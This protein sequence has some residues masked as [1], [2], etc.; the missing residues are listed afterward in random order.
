MRILPAVFCIVLGVALSACGGGGSANVTPAGSGNPN[1]APALTQ[2]TTLQRN[3]AQQGLSTTYTARNMV[4]DT[5]GS[6]STLA[7]VRRAVEARRFSAATTGCVDSEIETT[8]VISSTVENL[9]I[10][11]Y[12]D[13]ACTQLAVLGQFVLTVTSST[14]ATAAGSYTYYTQAGTIFEYDGPVTITFGG[15]GTGS[16]YFATSSS[17]ATSRLAIPYGSEGFGCSTTSS[18]V[19]CT[20]AAVEHW[21]SSN[22]DEGQSLTL[23]AAL[24]QSGSSSTATI[25]GTGNGYTA[26]FDALSVVPQG[27]SSFAVSGA[28]ASLSVSVNASAAFNAGVLGGE[29]LT[30]TDAPDGA[31]LEMSYNA[32]TQLLGGTV[33]QTGTGLVLATFSVSSISGSGTVTYGNGTTAQIVDWVIET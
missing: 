12:Y 24:T 19:T 29:T 15:L 26:A 31:T 21:T 32:A 11:S 16:E 2:N 33:M 13:T 17:V 20:S 8:T 28:A 27:V 6:A 22:D 1:N 14:S 25:S 5:S 10:Q 4:S 18:S 30:V 23:T 3:L 7:T 9:T